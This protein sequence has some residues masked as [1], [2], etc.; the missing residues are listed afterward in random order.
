[1]SRTVWRRIV[2]VDDAPA[3]AVCHDKARGCAKP[4]TTLVEL[5]NG[6]GIAVCQ[7]HY[8]QRGKWDDVSACY[9][10]EYEDVT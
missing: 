8:V 9:V 2:A 3:G 5:S 1:M 7:E 6:L 4:A 10:F